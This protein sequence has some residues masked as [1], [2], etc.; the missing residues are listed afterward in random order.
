MKR[1]SRIVSVLLVLCM[2]LSLIPSVFAADDTVDFAFLVTS[3]IHG[4]I[5]AT[6]YSSGYSSSGTY[7]Q[8]LTRVASYIKEMKAKYGENLYTVDMGDSIQGDRNGNTLTLNPQGD[9]TRAEAAAIMSRFVTLM[10]RG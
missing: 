9:A 4:K 7:R 6:D 10:K 5:Y 8:G 2:I 3:D 1:L